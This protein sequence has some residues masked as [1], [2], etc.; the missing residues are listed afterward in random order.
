MSYDQAADTCPLIGR[1]QTNQSR[2]NRH[3]D[4]GER[5]RHLSGDLE[6]VDPSPYFT[7]RPLTHSFMR[8]AQS[9]ASFKPI[10]NRKK[11]YK[12]SE[13]LSKKP[14]PR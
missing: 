1:S 13:L 12:E 7:S 5:I 8:L 4:D 9:Y 2:T 10:L 3:Q 6:A 14:Y 11:S